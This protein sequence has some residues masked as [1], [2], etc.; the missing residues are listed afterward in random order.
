MSKRRVRAK[1]Y[2]NYRAARRIPLAIGSFTK[3]KLVRLRDNFTFTI[4]SPAAGA[5]GQNVCRHFAMNDLMDPQ[6]LGHLIPSTTFPGFKQYVP[7]ASFAQYHAALPPLSTQFAEQYGKATV[8]GT[9]FNFTITND[10][11]KHV[12]DEAGNS[13]RVNAKIWYAYRTDPYSK[14]GSAFPEAPDV[15]L[16]YDAL[17]ETGKWTMGIIN[18]GGVDTF[19]MKKFSVTYTNKMWPYNFGK[20]DGQCDQQFTSVDDDRT[21]A[22]TGAKVTSIAAQNNIAIL[23]IVCGP[24]A[25]FTKQPIPTGTEDAAVFE[26]VPANQTRLNNVKVQVKTEYMVSLGDLKAINGLDADGI[27]YPKMPTLDSHYKIAEPV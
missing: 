1:K 5:N 20:P 9:K 3:R 22:A 14:L 26:N 6:L 11:L 8:I 15:A 7:P 24:M 10:C 18:G 12:N 21:G 2:G 16:T 17:K 4:D 23:R 19:A 25:D 13:T 27:I